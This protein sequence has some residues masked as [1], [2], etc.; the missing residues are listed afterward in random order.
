MGEGFYILV[1]FSN[2]GFYRFFVDGTPIRVFKNNTNI[3][4]NYPMHPLQIEA[5]I[6][7]APWADDGNPVNWSQA[8]F[9]AH[10]QGFG[11][12]GCSTQITNAQECAS[13]NLWRNNKKYW[14]LDPHQQLAY[15]NV[16]KKYMVYD[17][18]SDKNRYPK[19]PPE[20]QI[21]K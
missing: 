17:Y 4:V 3:G 13:S 16:R 12:D 10:Y 1:C 8:P 2:K 15:E 14:K 9:Q 20:C 19:I 18:C 5:T 6:W 21:N 11:I 7:N